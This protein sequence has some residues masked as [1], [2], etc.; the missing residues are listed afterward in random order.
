MR[1]GEWLSDRT[2]KRFGLK[3]LNSLIASLLLGLSLVSC[4]FSYV[5]R[6]NG[7]EIRHTLITDCGNISMQMRG[8]GASL[9]SLNCVYYPDPMMEIRFDSLRIDLNSTPLALNSVRFRSGTTSSGTVLRLEKTDSSLVEF[10]VPSGVFEGDTLWVRFNGMVH[11]DTPAVRR[12]YFCFE[13]GGVSPERKAAARK[14]GS[15][16]F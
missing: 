16:V 13:R 2:G 10:R 5:V 12:F 7:E 3:F 1:L 14:S 9:F 6:V 4:R 11:C 8:R 15:I